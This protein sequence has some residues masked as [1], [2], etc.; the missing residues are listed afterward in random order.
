MRNAWETAILDNCPRAYRLGLGPR[1]A[2]AI[3]ALDSQPIP[4]A[5]AS[6]SDRVNSRTLTPVYNICGG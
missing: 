1:S 5:M 3:R 2:M 6:L 4:V